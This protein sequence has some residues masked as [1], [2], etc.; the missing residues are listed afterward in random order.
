MAR[1]VGTAINRTLGVSA[2]SGFTKAEVFTT[3]GTTTWSVPS[4][5]KKLKVFVIGA[6]SDYTAMTH[7]YA[8][9]NCNSGVSSLGCNYCL[10][11]TG[12]SPGA[13]GGFAERLIKDP[14]GV[15]TITVG[16]KGSTEA[17]APTDSSFSLPGNSVSITA[18]SARKI[19]V[20][21]ACVG[22]STARDNSNDLPT[23][24][25]FQLPICGY[26]NCVSGYWQKPGNAIGGD[27]NRTGGSSIIIPEFLCDSNIRPD[28]FQSVSPNVTCGLA[29][30]QGTM[31]FPGTGSQR[32]NLQT[33]GAKC[34]GGT[35]TG[36]PS[37]SGG[38][39]P[40]YA[41]ICGVQV[42]YNYYYGGVGCWCACAVAISGAAGG[43]TVTGTLS[44][45]YDP[46]FKKFSNTP[47]GLGA[48]SGLSERN[49][50][51]AKPEA[52][53]VTPIFDGGNSA[54]AS[55]GSG[56]N[57]W[58]VC[59]RDLI[60]SSFGSM[61]YCG[62]FS[63]TIPE[64]WV[65]QSNANNCTNGNGSKWCATACNCT[66]TGGTTPAMC[67][68]NI[69]AGGGSMWAAQPYYDITYIQTETSLSELSG[70]SLELS[71]LSNAAETGLSNFKYG[72]GAGSSAATFGG[73]GNRCYPAGNGAV[74]VLY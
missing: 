46:S 17:T 61:C 33:A 19:P 4:D 53:T 25:G 65:C 34:V 55:S 60:N 52:F 39:A 42:G 26:I 48:S 21:W 54:N 1:F 37:T 2:V 36:T 14:I 57:T 24:I 71:A 31:F 15:A 72:S 67:F 69:S 12:H 16:Q 43:G 56:G 47:I 59:V 73:G 23:S 13:G 20:N 10:T 9:T 8:S 63:M 18:Y 28:S 35:G 74:V 32:Q 6:G 29:C 66:C 11:F 49:G 7:C 45:S 40:G 68:P 38:V 64:G 30:T 22:N 5:A 62:C 51:A 58:C 27:I 3:P 50:T 70:E 44:I 41:L